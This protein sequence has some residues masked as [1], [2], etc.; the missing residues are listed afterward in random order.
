[1]NSEKELS[2]IRRK[3]RKQGCV[4]VAAEEFRGSVR[5]SGTVSTWERKID[6]GWIAAGHG[7]HGVIN[8]IVVPGIEEE[9]LVFPAATTTAAAAAGNPDG[10]GGS[11]GRSSGGSSGG[12]MGNTPL[13]GREFDV[14]IIGG[15]VIGC[16]AAREL[17]RHDI[18]IALFEKEEDLAVHST[19]RNDGMIHPGLA[20]KP[21]SRKAHYN[22][23]GNRLYTRLAEELGIPFF[24][25]GSMILFKGRFSRFLVPILTNRARKNGVDGWRVLSRKE[26]ARREPYL[27]RHQ[28]GAFLLES[29]GV[30]SPYNLTVA[31]AENAAQNSAEIFLSTGVSGF[32]M[33]GGRIAA[34]ETTRGR[35]SA[36]VVINA[37]G[38]WADTVAGFADDRFFSIHGR[39]G[40]D[41]I[42]D[43]RVGKYLSTICAKPSLFQIHEKTKG[44]GLVLTVDGNV[45]VGPTA[46]EVPDREKYDTE[47]RDLENLY[48]HIR[49]NVKFSPAD[50]ITYFAG[51]RACTYDEDF[52]VEASRRVENLVHAAGIQ[53]PG[54]AS[55]PAIAQDLAGL[56]IGILSRSGVVRAR[57]GFDPVRKAPPVPSRM[58]DA[59]RN[60]LIRRDRAYGRIICRCEEV[61]EGEVRDALRSPVP[62]GSLDGVKR[63]SRTGMGRCHGGFCTPR[64]IEIMAGE[65]GIDPSMI[66]KKG[67]GSS[68]FSGWTKAPD[69]EK[70]RE[71]K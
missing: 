11:T 19:G 67:T 21:G 49:L 23:R 30:L 1:M 6:A 71:P 24:R 8:D 53:S 40:V 41:C 43:K 34:V 27:E 7:F 47:Y 10:M 46:R 31:L 3:L 33:D 20:A 58:T 51:I 65:L 35:V 70:T 15:G 42:L 25:P 38:I 69:K 50:I 16:A 28:Y 32:V 2:V 44:G 55:A 29:T 39:H 12:R 63:R 37:A 36:K 57:E 5:L 22:I 61:S 9:K 13:D 68:I 59:E 4:D 64:V 48:H 54:L 66:T 18:R 52:I 62:A 56:A 45:L 60:E 17:S 26:V 14:V